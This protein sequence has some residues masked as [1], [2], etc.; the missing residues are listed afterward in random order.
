MDRMLYMR[1]I[2]L[3][4]PYR[5]LWTMTS[6]T[7]LIWGMID[8][9]FEMDPVQFEIEF[10][11]NEMLMASYNAG[12]LLTKHVR[13]EFDLKL[14]DACYDQLSILETMFVSI[15]IKTVIALS[16]LQHP[17]EITFVR[18]QRIDQIIS[19]LQFF[20]RHNSSNCENRLCLVEATKAITQGR[21]LEALQLY[22]QAIESAKENKMIGTEAFSQELLGRMWNQQE[23]CERY[24]KIHIQESYQLYHKWGA[25]SKLECIKREFPKM[26][27]DLEID[28]RPNSSIF[29]NL[30]LL[31]E[32]SPTAFMSGNH[33]HHGSL[34]DVPAAN[35][36]SIDLLTVMQ[37]SQVISSDSSLDEFLFNM[38]KIIISNAG[39]SMGIFIQATP[40]VPAHQDSSSTCS[41]AGSTTPTGGN[42]PSNPDDPLS[43]TVIAE[44][45][46]DDEQRDTIRAIS[47]EN[48]TFQF[49]SSIVHHVVKKRETVVIS[50]CSKANALKQY[51][52]EQD[53]QLILDRNLQSIL[54]TPIIKHNDFKGVL[55]L[56]K[57][58]SNESSSI[59]NSSANS[60]NTFTEQRIKVIN[61]L[62][63]QMVIS[64]ENARFSSLLE[65]EKRFRTLAA[66]LGVVKK[67]LEEFI[68]VLCHE[69]RNPLNAIFGNKEIISDLLQEMRNKILKYTESCKQS[70][71]TC[72]M[73]QI[74]TIVQEYLK[75]TKE[76]VKA[77][78][79]S[80]DHLKDIVD[81]VLTVS[82]LESHAVKLQSIPFVPLDMITMVNIMFKAKVEEKKLQLKF[83]TIQDVIPDQ[84]V[85]LGDPYRFKEILI[86][87]VSNA[88]KFTDAGGCITVRY[89]EL[90][91]TDTHVTLQIEVEDTGIGLTDAEITK[92]FQP[93]SQANSQTYGKYGGSGLGLKISKE[94][95]EHMGGQIK[96]SSQI[97]KGSKFYFTLHLKQVHSNYQNGYVKPPLAPVDTQRPSSSLITVEPEAV[98]SN[99]TGTAANT[100][101]NTPIS[102]ALSNRPNPIIVNDVDDTE[103]FQGN[104]QYKV[105]IVEDNL[106]NQKLL[107]RLIKFAGYPLEVAS[108]GKEAVDWVVKESFDIIL[109]DVEMPVMNGI[110]ATRR[111]RQLEQEG[112]LNTKRKHIP[113]IGVSA[114]A[115]D[116]FLQKALGCGMDWYI[117]KPYLKR[118]IYDAINRWKVDQAVTSALK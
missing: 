111:I 32:S 96:V 17:S 112:G 79:I 55:Y 14:C 89:G 117:T 116:E 30:S 64:L 106:I 27:C 19:D 95:V 21:T 90:N 91:R 48:Y 70:N 61:L 6:N 60:K 102:D 25:T 118:D 7:T 80:S 93:F 53:V 98:D 18:N 72:E 28:S 31:D 11:D 97:K 22:E 58:P 54:C 10:G 85:V 84:L 13:G 75:E 16:Y 34:G 47:L 101:A 33:G 9:H 77:M 86:N 5:Y 66:E 8:H 3:M 44:I 36:K 39:A 104:H 109:M 52:T 41:S 23:H 81:T 78:T 15:Q 26:I 12:I 65:S 92:L 51:C 115:R 108:N 45:S 2:C 94:I 43:L 56:E 87:L 38:M 100:P 1:G 99:T 59:N 46:A 24:A 35:N 74:R 113:I 40:I 107:A 42:A 20:S 114:N 57:S 4:M 103:N 69:L 73:D 82:M 83:E 67:K 63:A 71:A 68:N 62:T 110:E 49:P 37:A 76:A 50:D 105:L 29:S 88:I